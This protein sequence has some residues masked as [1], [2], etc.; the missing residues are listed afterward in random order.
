[1]DCP[2][3]AQA[4]RLR[5]RQNGNYPRHGF[6]VRVP[7][8]PRPTR[9]S[10]PP[11]AAPPLARARSSGRGVASRITAAGRERYHRMKRDRLFVG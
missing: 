10:A 9:R 3:A 6:Y 1:M 4:E 7:L 8:E 2:A 5:A 11:R